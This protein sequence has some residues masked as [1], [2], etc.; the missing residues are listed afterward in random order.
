[1]SWRD[2]P[3]EL[4]AEAL[5]NLDLGALRVVRAVDRRARALAIQTVRDEAWA[6]RLAV[7]RP[8][9]GIGLHN[10]D[11]LCACMWAEGSYDIRELPSEPTDRSVRAMSLHGNRLA[12]GGGAA[13][14]VPGQRNTRRGLVRIWALESNRSE[15][16][17][18]SALPHEL[19]V[20][21]VALRADAAWVASAC[22]TVVQA[23][24]VAA[25]VQC[26]DW[27]RSHCVNTRGR[28]RDRLP[29]RD[30]ER[31]A[32]PP[33]GDGGAPPAYTHRQGVGH[34]ATV[35]G[36]AWL[37]G[38]TRLLSGA[39]DGAL[40]VWRADDLAEADR[41]GLPLQCTAVLQL[42]EWAVCS[43]NNDAASDPLAAVDRLGTS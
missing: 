4:L 1:M 29:T 21:S 13:Y 24:D 18:L 35:T 22:S 43:S 31:A 30:E 38:P 5:A 27:H 23:W 10:R 12:S 19:P 14:E 8:R 16:P 34:A 28:F 11:E 36:L 25:C 42:V 9:P 32:F 3:D 6:L 40:R 2:L 7:S 33:A 37:S 39:M 26:A 17:C 20:T 15:Q 41:A